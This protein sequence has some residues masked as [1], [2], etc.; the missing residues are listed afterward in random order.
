MG[1]VVENYL[2]ALNGERM[3]VGE[4]LP[5][6][7]AVEGVVVQTVAVFGIRVVTE[8]GVFEGRQ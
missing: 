3:T 5:I 4:D 2:E 6:D 1:V 8:R 7:S